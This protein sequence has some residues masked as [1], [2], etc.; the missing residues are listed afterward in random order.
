MKIEELSIYELLEHFEN[1]VCDN[2]YNPTSVSFNKSEFF[3]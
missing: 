2:N 1:A 3:I